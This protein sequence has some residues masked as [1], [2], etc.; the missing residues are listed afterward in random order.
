MSPYFCHGVASATSEGLFGHP[1]MALEKWGG[2]SP[3]IVL[4]L[5]FIYIFNL[6]SILLLVGHVAGQ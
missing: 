2:R 3:Y 4:L 5:Y 6:N 1:Q